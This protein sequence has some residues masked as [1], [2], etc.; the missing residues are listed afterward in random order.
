MSDVHVDFFGCWWRDI[1][2]KVCVLLQCPVD[3]IELAYSRVPPICS[4]VV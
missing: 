1:Y 2:R 4:S 3:L